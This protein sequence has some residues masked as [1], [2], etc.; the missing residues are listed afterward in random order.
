MRTRRIVMYCVGFIALQM[1]TPPPPALASADSCSGA[2]VMDTYS[3]SSA[4][5]SDW[6]LADLVD[7]G[8]YDQI[9]HD[10]G[11][12]AVIYGV[13]VGANYDDFKQEVTQYKHSRNEHLTTNQLVNIAWTG[14]D[15]NSPGAYAQCLN[16]QVFLSSGLH[17]A[18]RAATDSNIIILVKW[19]VPGQPQHAQIAW[20]PSVIGNI[21]LPTDFPQGM[22]TI[23]VPRPPQ[24]VALAGSTQGWTTD[25]IILEPLP[26]PPPPTTS[27]C[28]K[29]F[30]GQQAPVFIQCNGFHP[31]ALAKSRF[32]WNYWLC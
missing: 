25:A 29:S 12:S 4:V 14:L 27:E 7:R 2:L 3:G 5:S 32:E 18:V 10:A 30:A 17:A 15:P 19:D 20:T 26:L 16:T 31:H 28:N 23:S 8:T 9:K 13:P 1:C 21:T 11:A 24:Q 6:R 22:T